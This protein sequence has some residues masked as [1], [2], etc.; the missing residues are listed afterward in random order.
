MTYRLLI[1][2][3]RAWTDEQ[4]IRDAIAANVRLYGPGNLVIVHGACPSGADAMADR[5][6]SAWGGGLTV[7]RHPA[8]WDHCVPA[9]PPGHRRRKPS[10]DVD[11][12]GLLDTYCPGAGPRRNAHMVGLGADV[13]LAFLVRGSRGATHTANAA[14]RA[15]ILTYRYEVEA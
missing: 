10:G 2:G 7:E 8:D 13:C 14:K 15:G 11:H 1:T 3:S 5:I 12:P 9:C 4:R 6:A